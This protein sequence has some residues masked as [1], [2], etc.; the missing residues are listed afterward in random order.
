MKKTSHSTAEC[1]GLRLLH[2]IC[3]PQFPPR[4]TK[5]LLAGVHGRIERRNDSALGGPACRSNVL[6]CCEFVEDSLSSFAGVG[7]GRVPKWGSQRSL[8][9][10]LD[11]SV[12]NS[13]YIIH[14]SPAISQVLYIPSPAIGDK[15]IDNRGVGSTA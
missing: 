10:V 1:R 7:C 14:I 15:S 3:R 8:H 9:H 13:L 2:G 12:I 4:K 5:N 11:N 6:S